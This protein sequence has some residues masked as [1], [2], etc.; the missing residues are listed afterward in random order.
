MLKQQ[1]VD[2]D[3]IFAIYS[4]Q[5][6]AEAMHAAT[7]IQR[8]WRGVLARTAL[9]AP[10]GLVAETC[11][12]KI[13]CMV[14]VVWAKQR[15]QDQRHKKR[16][17]MANVIQGWWQEQRRIEALQL[18]H[19]RRALSGMRRLQAVYR[20]NLR[21]RQLLDAYRSQMALRIQT[22]V[23]GFLG[24]RHIRRIIELTRRMTK[25]LERI[26]IVHQYIARCGRCSFKLCT[27]ASLVDCIM[28]RR[29]GLHDVDGAKTLCRDGLLKFPTSSYFPLLY[30]I[31]LI[32][33]TEP[34][35]V[36]ML[37][38]EKSKALALQQRTQEPDEETAPWYTN[39]EERYLTYALK[40]WPDD[41]AILLDYAVF[42]NVRGK[43][44]ERARCIR[45]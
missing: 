40:R 14:R 17:R 19:A 26:T 41:A 35:E 9:W 33:T 8:I 31:L 5:R 25:H 43:L 36:S 3:F 24:R 23:R 2:E 32:I 10:H 45:D 1:D 29:L 42:C 27:E 20:G 38:V 37:Y 22:G 28:A 6:L 13:Q 11:G 15:V 34:L 21:F 30:A 39:L 18:E 7:Q 4:N 44:I 16:V 12:L